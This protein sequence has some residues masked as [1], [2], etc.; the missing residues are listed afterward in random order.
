MKE[1][2]R[3]TKQL[4]YFTASWCGP[5]QQIKPTFKELVTNYPEIMFSAVDVD[6]NKELATKFNI[7]SM[8]TFVAVFNKNEVKRISGADPSKLRALV[9][10]LMNL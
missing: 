4:L 1:K 10:H 6:E 8:P 7:K 3:M 5:C 9:E 2:F